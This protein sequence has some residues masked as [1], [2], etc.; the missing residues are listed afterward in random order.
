MLVAGA[1]W[2]RW[3]RSDGGSR[4]AA[5]LKN[6]LALADCDAGSGTGGVG[7]GDDDCLR[8]DDSDN[9]GGGGG[10]G[11]DGRFARRP[12]K[13]RTTPDVPKASSDEARPAAMA[14]GAL[15]LRW[16]RTT[17]PTATKGSKVRTTTTPGDIHDD[18]PTT[19]HPLDPTK[20]NFPANKHKHRHNQRHKEPRRAPAASAQASK[21]VG[22]WEMCS[23][24][25][26]EGH[27]TAQYYSASARSVRAPFGQAAQAVLP[28][29][30]E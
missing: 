6:H 17:Q 10:G 12:W 28:A 8:G 13:V 3:P 14:P 24:G 23:A 1:P 2:A 26:G 5:L 7:D 20:E 4:T 25:G 30:A 22:T 15:A 16:R 19:T 11:E 21:V 9:N 18:D 29:S 27:S